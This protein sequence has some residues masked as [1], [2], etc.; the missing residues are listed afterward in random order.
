MHGIF[1]HCCNFGW[2]NYC[3]TVEYFILSPL[4]SSFVLFC[5]RFRCH[6]F[7][8]QTAHLS[9]LLMKDPFFPINQEI[10]LP[11]LITASSLSHCRPSSSRSRARSRRSPTRRTW[12]RS[13]RRRRRC[14]T[15]STASR[16]RKSSRAAE[17]VG[18]RAASRLRRRREMAA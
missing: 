5:V 2:S 3:I 7:S 18:G 8:Y 11:K 17:G 6:L 10:S 15:R 12:W 16:R 13:R 14:A 4:S 1:S 9:T